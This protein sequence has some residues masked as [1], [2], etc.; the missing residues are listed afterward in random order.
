[1]SE[2]AWHRYWRAP[3]WPGEEEELARRGRE[4]GAAFAGGLIRPVRHDGFAEGVARFEVR[5]YEVDGGGGGG[6]KDGGFRVDSAC[7]MLS[8]WEKMEA[9]CTR[10]F[11]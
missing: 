2:G 9:P 7:P 3:T 4:S 1:M 6:Q 8:R 11:F 10:D 5:V